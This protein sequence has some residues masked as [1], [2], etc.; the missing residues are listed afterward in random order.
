MNPD[1]GQLA[2]SVHDFEAAF[3]AK[4]VDL[5]LSAVDR[6]PIAIDGSNQTVMSLGFA[7]AIVR[8]TPVQVQV[9]D[10]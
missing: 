2:A 4:R 9:L 1:D 5:R 8:Q 3:A 10:P 6:I 7:A